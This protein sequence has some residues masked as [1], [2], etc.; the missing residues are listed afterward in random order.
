M[1]AAP[2]VQTL[3][4]KGQNGRVIHYPMTVSDV[5]AAFALGPDSADFIQIPADQNYSLI[6]VIVVTG[7]TDTNWQDIF[8]NGLASGLRIGNKIN[9]NTSNFRQYASAPVTFKPGTVLKLKQSA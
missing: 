4:F 3:I 9:L 7:G 1:A 5:A 6:D 8:A 2:F